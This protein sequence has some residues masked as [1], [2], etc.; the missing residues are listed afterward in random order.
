MADINPNPELQDANTALNDAIEA[1]NALSTQLESGVEP[2]FPAQIQDDNTN[3]DLLDA[4]TL[5]PL[6]VAPNGLLLRG[7]DNPAVVGGNPVWVYT[8]NAMVRQAGLVYTQTAKA[9]ANIWL[10]PSKIARQI[11]DK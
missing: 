5:H 10:L 8:T 6:N 11:A 1:Y 4:M 9:Y 7:D 2:P 3:E